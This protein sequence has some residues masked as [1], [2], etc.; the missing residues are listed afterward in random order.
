MAMGATE[1]P[2]VPPRQ[3]ALALSLDALLARGD[4]VD[5]GET[6]APGLT[7]SERADIEAAR[8]RTPDRS[9][10]R[11]LVLPGIL[12]SHLSHSGGGRV[13][14]NPIGLAAGGAASL[15]LGQA[16]LVA[17]EPVW[18]VYAWLWARLRLSGF[19]AEV[20]PFDWRQPIDALGQGLA[21][22]IAAEDRPVDL[23]CHSMGGLVA[24][25][26]LKAGAQ[27]IGRIITLGTP[28][29]GSH[30]VVR[31]FDGSHDIVKGLAAIDGA[32]DPS[33]IARLLAGF[34][35]M[36]GMIPHPDVLAGPDF[37]QPINWPAGVN[38]PKDALLAA[39]LALREALPAAGAEFH[40]LVGTGR[41]TI[42]SAEVSGGRIRYF[43]GDGDGTVARESALLPGANAWFVAAEHGALPRSARAVAA[44][45]ALLDG[46]RPELSSEAP[47]P[48]AVD[49]AMASRLSA[50]AD[51]VE[52]FDS[53]VADFLRADRPESASTGPAA[54]AG[55]PC[56]PG[57][58]KFGRVARG[59]L[60]VGA[61]RDRRLEIRVAHGSILDLPSDCYVLGLFAGVDPG[62]GAASAVDAEMGGAISRLREHRL[63][64]GR[65]GEIQILPNGRHPLR[66]A[67]LAFAGL[68]SPALFRPESMAAVGTGLFRCLLAAR[69]DEA[70]MVPF[71]T[72]IGQ[73]TKD[74]FGFFLEGA[75]VA[76][77]ENPD[78]RFRGLTIC[79]VAPDKVE[80]LRGWLNDYAVSQLAEDFELVIDEVRLPAPTRRATASAR[81]LAYLFLG[82]ATEPNDD[83]LLVGLLTPSPMS[84]AA[85]YRVQ[86]GEVGAVPA[87]RATLDARAGS[88]EGVEAFGSELAATILPDDVAAGIR[89][90]GDEH[91]AVV[92]ASIGAVLPW[93][94][95]SIAGHHPALLGGMSRRYLMPDRTVPKWSAEPGGQLRILLYADP[96][97]DL[98]G[99][100]REGER[101]AALAGRLGRGIACTSRFRGAARRETLAADLKESFHIFHY[102]GHAEFDDRVPANSGLDL[103]DGR[104]SGRDLSAAGRLP[105]LV[106]LN[107]CESG[108]TRSRRGGRAAEANL[109]ASLAEAF[110][111]RGVGNLL[112]TY[113]PVGDAAADLFSSRFYD[114]ILAGGSL[115][116]AIVSGRRALH[117]AGHPDWANYLFYGDPHAVLLPDG[118]PA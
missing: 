75:L 7:P 112:A 36:A 111:Q 38:R 3:S 102:A 90:L 23:V 8:A 95:L 108:R 71:A 12:G 68:G 79:D 114:A 70:A 59:R 13:W 22:K 32:H 10:R 88:M 31:A 116:A 109:V 115:N 21:G 60:V 29:G 104:F 48:R 33:E 14:I 105:R 74:S 15:A 30:A 87:L 26:A 45:L 43:T 1:A 72:R 64:E 39:A 40:T 17:D 77:R 11:V 6:G 27:R 4:G 50:G 107:A 69:I 25:A 5:R 78:Q 110:L 99:A 47:A 46:Q 62:G 85:S 73:W 61:G 92:H 94:T 18:L 51:Q 41:P 82:E 117:D 42:A 54:V 91:L 118:K 2:D 28:H 103:A 76:L 49:R 63:I 16:D 55:P 101:I 93:E 57:E 80:E 19:N 113:W 100:M 9:G 81:Q 89:A 67:T 24:R 65:L 35:G 20:V 34:P 53:A 58:R 84:A 96:T 52:T 44:V 98:D 37:C 106:F 86:P 66:A 97:A 56:D 83:R